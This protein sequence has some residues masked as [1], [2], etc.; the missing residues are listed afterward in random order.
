[1]TQTARI[2]L[3]LLVCLAAAW[4]A[5]DKYDGPK[6]PVP[7]VPFLLHANNLVETDAAQATEDKKKDEMTY[8][9]VGAGATAR[10][11]LAEPVFI[12]ESGKIAPENLELYR[13]DVRNGNRE[14]VQTKKRGAKAYRL[15]V[16]PLQG[17]LYRIE[18]NEGMGLENGQYGLTPRDSNQVFCFEV[19]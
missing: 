8:R 6:P 9:V 3:L 17:K 1:M 2:P 11:P 10:T 5:A 14:V 7:D 13:F 16:T 18:V 19:Y 4:P 15:L 12:F